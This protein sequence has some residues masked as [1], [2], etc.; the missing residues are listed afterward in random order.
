M[1]QQL[2]RLAMAALAL[3]LLT[4]GAFA[5]SS[6][7]PLADF[8]LPAVNAPEPFQLSAAK[9]R[10]VAL[11]FLL[12][13]ECPVCLRT[14]QEYHRRGQEIAGV[15]QIFIK[16]DS[17]EEIRAFLRESSPG[18]PIIHR[19]ANAT[20]AK[21]IGIP[22]GYQ[23]H[24]ETMHFP[25]T[26]L[27]DREG[28]EV[29]RYVGKNNNDRLDFT[30]FL[31]EFNKRQP[32]ADLKHYNLKK[33]QPAVAGYDVV[34]YQRGGPEKGFGTFASTYRGVI[35]HFASGENRMRFNM[36]PDRYVPTYGGW[37]ATAMADGKKVSIDPTN[38]TIDEGRLNLFYK[39]FLGNAKPDWEK[40]YSELRP[41]ADT[42]WQRL[43]GE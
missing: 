11:H 8:T 2:I 22:N 13:T 36:D 21:T 27:V 34:S 40:K 10:F 33:D 43:T 16:P 31:A 17:E 6:T 29:Y 26:V 5:Q 19:D 42:A 15:Q 38:F 1:I 35:Y 25:A 20:L 7:Q 9:G 37:C 32:V 24:G 14:V 23:F 30:A 4:T 18:G 41:K 28:R 3:A 39:G 12:K